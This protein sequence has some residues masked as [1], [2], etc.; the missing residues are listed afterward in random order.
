VWS[1]AGWRTLQVNSQINAISARTR[2]LVAR[3]D[4]K[5]PAIVAAHRTRPLPWADPAAD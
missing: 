4:V 3:A 1:S 5:L 2:Q